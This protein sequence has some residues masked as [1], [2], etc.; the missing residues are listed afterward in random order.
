MPDDFEE[1][2]PENENAEDGVSLDSVAAEND[3]YEDFL[4]EDEFDN[5]EFDTTSNISVEKTTANW[6]NIAVVIGVVAIA[7]ALVYFL[8]FSTSNTSSDDTTAS[9]NTPFVQSD[10][11]V[12]AEQESIPQTLEEKIVD[13]GGLLSNL[14]LLKDDENAKSLIK[15]EE[16]KQEVFS[17]INQPAQGLSETEI[18]DLFASIQGLNNKTPSPP[19][20]PQ[21][22]LPLPMDNSPQV[23]MT[24]V[25]IL[26]T[27]DNDPPALNESIAETQMEIDDTPAE[28]VEQTKEEIEESNPTSPDLVRQIGHLNSQLQI[29][30]M[31]LDTALKKIETL[32]NNPNPIS[33]QPSIN[34]NTDITN[35]KETINALESKIK[36]LSTSPKR[37]S[38]KATYSPRKKVKKKP[39]V[40]WDLRGASPG[41]AYIAKSGTTNLRTINV[42]EQVEG[43]G[44]IQ[45]IALE[46]G[47]WIVLGSHGRITQ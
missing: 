38:K 31:R 11:N 1:K 42:G 13:S 26:K 43:L 15:Q 32:S 30:D 4:D 14:D 2:L 25:D 12:K 16:Q 9:G 7:G 47:R 46:H 21:Q 41:Q 22:P 29:M 39:A 28:L 23:S 45:S 40:K 3:F 6:M 33:G 18:D 8:F 44:K 36:S 24:E 20:A 34:N 10:P 19:E 37:S 27:M 35:L 5:D 17:D